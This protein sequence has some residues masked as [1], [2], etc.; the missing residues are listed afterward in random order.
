M[1]DRI[2]NTNIRFERNQKLHSKEQTEMIWTCDVDER[3]EEKTLHTKVDGRR[4]RRIPKTRWTDQIRKDI[5]MRG[6]N[7][8]KN[9]RKQEMR[10]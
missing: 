6:E 10:E 9:T 3:R 5:E 7:W 8:E 4:P 1:K 2:R